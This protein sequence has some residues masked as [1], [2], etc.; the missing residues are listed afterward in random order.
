LRQ[1]TAEAEVAV[2]PVAIRLTR[3]IASAERID[4]ILHLTCEQRARSRLRARLDDGREVGIL[5]ARGECVSSHDL[6]GSEDGT[7]VEVRAADEPVSTARSEDPTLIARAAYHLGNRHVSLEIRPGRLRWLR[8][9][10]LD[11]MIEGLGL[12]VVREHAPFEPEPGAY[13]G[14]AGHGHAH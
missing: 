14:S 3:R 10:V 2:E 7:V 4:A 13:G 9:H 8:D 12:E 11:G 1:P 5:L 6:L